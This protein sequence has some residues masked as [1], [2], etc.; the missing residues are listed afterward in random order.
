MSMLTAS[1]ITVV[2]KSVCFGEYFYLW[3]HSVLQFKR[4]WE[5]ERAHYSPDCEEPMAQKRPEGVWKQ[6]TG[7]SW[8]RRVCGLSGCQRAHRRL[9][10][11]DDI[12]SLLCL[13]GCWCHWLSGNVTFVLL[14]SRRQLEQWQDDSQSERNLNLSI[15]LLMQN[16]VPDGY[17]DGDHVKVDLRPESVSVLVRCETEAFILVYIVYWEIFC[18]IWTF[19]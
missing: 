16:K 1:D 7:N 12:A 13:T 14:D 17:E 9:E 8:R 2:I 6:N 19:N 5:D 18:H 4:S 3:L 11:L 10:R 15:P